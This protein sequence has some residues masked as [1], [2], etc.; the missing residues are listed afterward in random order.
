MDSG[1]ALQELAERFG[2]GSASEEAGRLLSFLRL[3]DKWNAR[4]NLTSSTEWPALE[5]LFE[6]ALWAARFY[7]RESAYHLD[8]GSGAGFPA[9]PMRILR[10]LMQLRLV[11]SRARRAAFLETVVSELR[12]DGS[13]V[14]CGRIEDLLPSGALPRFDIV[15]WKGLRLRTEALELLL[16]A[17]RPETRFWLFH[18]PALPLEDPGQAQKSLRLLQRESLPRHPSWRLSIYAIR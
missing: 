8:I 1:R 14:V 17:S 12:L 18:G 9:I 10:P 13:E 4:V 7:P 5:S 15:S 2:I 3:L 11:E 16:T 6:E